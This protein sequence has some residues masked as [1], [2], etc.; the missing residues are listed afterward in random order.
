[1]G[2]VRGAS[3]EQAAWL[4]NPPDIG[5]SCEVLL[6]DRLFHD[7]DAD[8]TNGLLAFIRASQDSSGAW[9]NATGQPDLSLSVLGWWARVQAGDDPTDD[10]MIR[11]RR[12]VHAM[13]GAQRAHFSVR[14]WLAMAGQIPWS[15][16]P[17]VPGE[18][19]LLP[20]ASWL[21]PS[22]FSPWARGMLVPY[23]VIARAPARLHLAD[24]APLLLERRPETP[25]PPRLT[26]PGLTGDVLQAIDRSVRLARKFPRGILSRWAIERAQANLCESQQDHGG[27]FSFRP[28]LLSLIALR[29]MGLTCDDARIERALGYLRRCRGR[30]KLTSGP[31]QGRVLLAQGQSG[32]GLRTLAPLVGIDL[33]DTDVDWLLEQELRQPGPWQSRADARAGGWSAEPGAGQHVDVDAT[34]RVLDAISGLPS[35]SSRAGSTWGATRRAIDLTLA[36][37]EGEGGFARFE[38]GESKVWM[39]ALPWQDADLLCFGESDDLVHIRLTGDVLAQLGGTGFRLDDDRVHRAVT[40]LEQHARTPLVQED[41]EVLSTLAR[42]VG[43]VCPP[44]HGLRQSLE[45]NLRARQHED[46]SFGSLV[47]TARAVRGLLGLG[48][49]CVQVIRAVRHII[50]SVDRDPDLERSPA[51]LREGGPTP[52]THDPSAT[53]LEIVQALGEYRRTS[54]THVSAARVQ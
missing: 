36:M 51:F 20:E 33:V 35:N 18:L 39:R 34:C 9:L 19:F 27:W 10:S 40:W 4:L 28:T 47:D 54:A 32:P 43:A 30:V 22:R 37:Q 53:A 49:P 25:V 31:E 38:R 7:L 8:E 3:I 24:A 11:A 1:M 44:E 2:V 14:L 21:S 23:Y 46:G 5:P 29:V 50:E 45:K 16:L 26:R 17:A 13:G 12:A 15:F 41:I 6:A 48:T 42:G 52:D